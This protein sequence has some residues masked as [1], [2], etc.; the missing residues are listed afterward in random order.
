MVDDS[1]CWFVSNSLAFYWNHLGKKTLFHIDYVCG[2][3][4]FSNHATQLKSV[5]LNSE[6]QWTIIKSIIISNFT[7][8]IS[9]NNPWYKYVVISIQN[10]FYLRYSLI[11]LYMCV[12]VFQFQSDVI[13]YRS[14]AESH[15]WSIYWK[16]F[17]RYLANVPKSISS[18]PFTFLPGRNQLIRPAFF[19]HRFWNES[20]FKDGKVTRL[21]FHLLIL[22]WN[23][24]S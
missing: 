5:G 8:P 19:R 18:H 12:C 22:F 7:Q 14:R 3:C 23:L 9:L 6:R 4:F 21:A 10:V 20:L 2:V 11:I 15:E 1:N 24:S 17:H 13:Q 16:I